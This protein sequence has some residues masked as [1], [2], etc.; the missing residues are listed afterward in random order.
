MQRQEEIFRSYPTRN[1]TGYAGREFF[2]EKIAEGLL[3]AYVVENN[4][5]DVLKD[6]EEVFIVRTFKGNHLFT[7]EAKEFESHSIDYLPSI[8]LKDTD[9]S[10]AYNLS[11]GYNY[12]SLKRHRNKF[13]GIDMQSLHVRGT[14]FSFPM[15][16]VD[17][18]LRVDAE[19]NSFEVRP[20][21]ALQDRLFAEYQ[22]FVDATEILDPQKLRSYEEGNREML[23]RVVE[24]AEAAAKK[25]GK[26]TVYDEKDYNTHIVHELENFHGFGIT[27]DNGSTYMSSQTVTIKRGPKTVL[28]LIYLSKG[29]APHVEKHAPGKW[30][31]EL[32][33]LMA[34]SL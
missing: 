19:K 32:E 1:R 4:P 8:L 5:Q 26:Q 23:K 24:F 31:P 34:N 28:K 20:E 3:C 10:A 6:D 18:E 25:I 27:H 30:E 29:D 11:L 33:T 22:E 14:A 13:E 21:S 16:D 15:A 9:T 17:A 7:L 12:V 2:T